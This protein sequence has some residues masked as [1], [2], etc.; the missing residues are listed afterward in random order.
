MMKQLVPKQSAAVSAGFSFLAAVLLAVGFSTTSAQAAEPAA[1]FTFTDSAVTA[2]GGTSGYEIDGTDLTI[3]SAG[4][5][6]ITVN[7]GAKMFK[8]VKALLTVKD[9]EMTAVLTLSGSGYSW[10]Y[11]GEADGIADADYADFIPAVIN[12]DGYTFEI[13]VEAL[14]QVISCA[15]YSR[16]KDA[17]Y[18]RNILFD[19]DTLPEDALK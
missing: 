12:G 1:T 10:F 16:A 6:E 3:T 15:A 7:T 9:G 18:P 14:D 4:T 19:A 13:P 5:Y 17:W 8:V 2:A 11:V